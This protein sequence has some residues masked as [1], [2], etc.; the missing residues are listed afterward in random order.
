MFSCRCTYLYS[1][2]ANK[3]SVFLSHFNIP[4]KG[5]KEVS[6]RASKRKRNQAGPPDHQID[7]TNIA[8]NNPQPH[9]HQSQSLSEV[10][11]IGTGMKI[12]RGCHQDSMFS[13]SFTTGAHNCG[14]SFKMTKEKTQ[15][16]SE[17]GQISSNPRLPLTSSHDPSVGIPKNLR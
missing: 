4:R 1:K 10:V 15:T 11:V 12:P 2:L 3:G 14:I 13:A 8:T 7:S 5:K 16:R 17:S 6:R 9:C